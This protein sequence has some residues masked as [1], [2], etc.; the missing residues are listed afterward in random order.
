MA[1]KK[2]MSVIKSLHKQVEEAAKTVENLAMTM[3]KIEWRLSALLE[4]ETG[5]GP[6]GT[7][8]P[9]SEPEPEPAAE[10][11]PEPAAEPEPEPAA[12]PEPEAVSSVSEPVTPSPPPSK[13]E[14]EPEAVSSVS[15]PVTPS[16]PPSEP[17]P[18]PE[19]IFVS[20]PEI[21]GTVPPPP[22][23]QPQPKPQPKPQPQQP[24]VP[25]DAVA[26]SPPDLTPTGGTIGEL[27][28]QFLALINQ[29]RPASELAIF[30]ENLREK[31]YQTAKSYHPS[32][33][34]MGRFIE[35][36]N[37]VGNLALTQEMKEELENEAI[38]WKTRLEES[39]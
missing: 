24:T 39:A 15:E 2:I 35:K 26:V 9:V 3:R 38:D 37:R 1:S 6:I 18:E 33:Y 8:E 4:E 14:P 34:T 31:L 12:E 30:L 7:F 22:Q 17:E 21:P 10:P 20:M 36:L 5:E 29:N 27:F 19:P 13:P 23:P 28:D 16:P 11:E 32:F 25:L